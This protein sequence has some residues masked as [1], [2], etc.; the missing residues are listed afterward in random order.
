MEFRLEKWQ[1]NYIDD[2]M[3]ATDDPHLSD[4]L[5][6]TL[7]YPMDIAY[8]HEYIRERMFNSEE[9]QICRAVIV[10]GHAVGSV[11]VVFGTGVFAKGGE[12]S[13]WLAKPYR[14]QGLGAEV[15]RA[16]SDMVFD[17]YDIIRIESHP[18]VNHAVASAALKKAGFSH[19]GTIHSAIFKN[20][21]VYDYDV[22]ARIK[23]KAD[24]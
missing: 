17:E 5:C 8:A 21:S 18:Y 13:I 12:L 14:L 19:E 6:E 2:F 22:Y 16:I 4:K 15:I 24:K 1:A 7:P 20:G 9:R 10:D 3:T 11:D 23:E